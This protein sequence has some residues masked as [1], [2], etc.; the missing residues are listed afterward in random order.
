MKSYLSQVRTLALLV[1]PVCKGIQSEIA[2]VA[3]I[4]VI[5]LLR[6][7]IFGWETAARPFIGSRQKRQKTVDISWGELIWTWL[8]TD[9]SGAYRGQINKPNE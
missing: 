9:G 2:V 4:L 5:F 1:D 7:D 6:C 8:A 3:Q